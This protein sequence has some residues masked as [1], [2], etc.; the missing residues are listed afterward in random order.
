[1]WKVGTLELLGKCILVWDRAGEGAVNPKSPRLKLPHLL[2]MDC[3][4]GGFCG[5]R[6]S[7]K[8]LGGVIREGSLLSVGIFG[9][10]ISFWFLVFVFESLCIP[11]YP[12]IM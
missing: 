1:M 10:V 4:F 7:W 2:Q 5:V 8:D 3:Q 12:R 11:G 6:I 9:F